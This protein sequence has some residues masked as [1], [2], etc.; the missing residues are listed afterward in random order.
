MM[1]IMSCFWVRI[2]HQRP[3]RNNTQANLI[4]VLSAAVVGD[5]KN[6]FCCETMI[7]WNAIPQGEGN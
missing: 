2:S 7:P 5:G 3:G 4:F 1:P 6:A